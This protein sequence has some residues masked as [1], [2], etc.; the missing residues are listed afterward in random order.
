MFKSGHSVNI[1]G[2]NHLRKM[3]LLVMLATVPGL[4]TL[5]YF[6]G[7]GVLINVVLA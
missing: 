4:I 5:T 7:W 6:F 1:H 2:D 3:M